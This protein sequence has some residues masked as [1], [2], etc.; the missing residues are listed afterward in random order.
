MA[1]RD[2]KPSFRYGGLAQRTIDNEVY[3]LIQTGL[4]AD[5]PA[6]TIEERYY[7]ATDELVLYRDTGTA[8][9]AALTHLAYTPVNKAGDT[10]LGNLGA[11]STLFVLRRDA[12]DYGGNFST[13]T[14]PTGVEGGMLVAEDTNAGSP[15]RRLYVYSGAA[16]RYVALS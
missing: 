4:I 2:I 5:R 13:Y 15:A 9:V 1:R 11:G 10:M 6:A 7:F 8:W 16:W 12:A 3:G 14:P